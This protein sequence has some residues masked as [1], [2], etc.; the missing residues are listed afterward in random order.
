MSK[1]LHHS[2]DEND[3]AEVIAIPRGFSPKTA[4]VMSTAEF[5]HFAVLITS[6]PKTA[7]VM[8]TAEFRHFAH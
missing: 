3:D 4:E 5:R 1:F 8:S 2:G 6:A 7:E